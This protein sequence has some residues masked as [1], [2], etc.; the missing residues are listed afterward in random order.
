M[1]NIIVRYESTPT[2]QES[3]AIGLLKTGADLGELTRND[4]AQILRNVMQNAG[5]EAYIH[6]GGSHVALCR[7]WQRVALITSKHLDWN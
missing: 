5:S 6:I 7:G 2:S 3:T 4:A 1:S